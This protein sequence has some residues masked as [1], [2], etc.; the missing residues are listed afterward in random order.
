MT[1]LEALNMLLRLIGATP[2]NDVNTTYP[3]A[4]NARVTLTRLR[5]KVQKR[6]WWFNI[7]YNLCYTPN[8]DGEIVVSDDITS[9][10]ADNPQFVLRGQKMYDKLNQTYIFACSVTAIKTIRTLE[11]DDMPESVREYAAYLAGAEFVRDEVEDYDKVK[12]LHFDAGQ[13]LIEV[14]KEDLEA[15]QYNMFNSQRTL[16]ARK[17]VQPYHRSNKRF[18]GDPDV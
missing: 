12:S 14:K 11:W 5:R 2:V 8:E 7:D 15:G 6:G 18:H 9:L 3:E 1:E 16:Q 13:S 17:G 10:V 4:A